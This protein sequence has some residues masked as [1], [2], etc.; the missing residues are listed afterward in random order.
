MLAV[1]QRTIA[2]DRT[3]DLAM[4]QVTVVVRWITR[5]EWFQYGMIVRRT[6]YLVPTHRNTV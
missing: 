3:H 2:G 6:R 1:A 5:T 4:I